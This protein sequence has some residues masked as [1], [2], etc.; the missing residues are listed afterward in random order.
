MNTM[1]YNKYVINQAE[2]SFLRRCFAAY[3]IKDFSSIDFNNGV[4]QQAKRNYKTIAGLGFISEV[5][6]EFKDEFKQGL[7]WIIGR[8]YTHD[9]NIIHDETA[10]FGLIIGI[11]NCKYLPLYK[12]WLEEILKI[13]SNLN[14][15]EQTI[16]SNYFLQ[17]INGQITTT[18]NTELEIELSFFFQSQ[19]K[20]TF[21]NHSIS[22]NYLISLKRKSF[23]Y[24]DNN[25]FF[26]N[27]IANS[28]VEKISNQ[29]ILDYEKLK[30]EVSKA[31]TEIKKQFKLILEKDAKRYGKNTLGL[32]STIVLLSYIIGFIEIYWGNWDF[33]EPRTFLI[34]GTPILS[35]LFYIL[36][37]LF[38]EKEFNLSP[39]KIFEN[40]KETKFKE[41]IKKFNL[42]NES[43]Q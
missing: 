27:L 10:I 17:F 21:N 3:L 30:E 6:D 33:W 26:R 22:S 39:K 41:L 38:R 4:R 9:D 29:Y 14:K 34:F 23:P 31:E 24:Y 2:N 37:F 16:Y 7:D 8:E 11:K 40:L 36:Y 28:N 19:L 15:A 12:E 13:K 25:N 18:G 32:I 1:S 5:S 42:E 35:Y 43:V 20:Q